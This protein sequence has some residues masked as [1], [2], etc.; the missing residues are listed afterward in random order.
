MKASLVIASSREEVARNAPWAKFIEP[1]SELKDGW[2]ACDTRKAYE[3]AFASRAK[4][5]PAKD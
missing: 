1:L 3:Y 5:L 2:L 4:F